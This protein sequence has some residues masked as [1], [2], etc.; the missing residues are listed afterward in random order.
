MYF[1]ALE[2]ALRLPLVSVQAL[3]INS[4]F[5]NH[6]ECAYPYSMMMIRGGV[7]SDTFLKLS[8]APVDVI[9]YA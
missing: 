4:F 6:G 5:F 3:P 1:E 2:Q 9:S 8:G 7:F